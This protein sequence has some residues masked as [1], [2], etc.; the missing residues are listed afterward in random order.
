MLQLPQGIFLSSTITVASRPAAAHSTGRTGI[1]AER[2]IEAGLPLLTKNFRNSSGFGPDCENII[3]AMNVRKLLDW[4]KLLIYSHRWMGIAGGLLF[5][6]WF[7]SGVVIMYKG[8][9]ELT[10]EERLA[11]LPPVDL[12][13]ARL[14]P[15]EAAAEWGI[16]PTRVR[17]EMFYDGRP[18]YRFQG[19]TVVFAED[20]TMPPGA[21]AEEAVEFV[22]RWAPRH[23]A[24]VEYDGYLEDS[25][26]WTLQ[27]AQRQYMPLHRIAL[28]DPADTYYYVSEYTGEPVMK[29][30][31]ESRWW[32]F[33]SA[34]LH[35]VYFVPLRRETYW[36]NQFII[37]GSFAGAVMC[38]S[39][40]FIGIW[41]FSPG[42]RFRQSTRLP[43]ARTRVGC[44][45]ITMPDCYL[46]SSALPGLSAERF[47]L[48]RTAGRLEPLRHGNNAKP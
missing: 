44:D 39:G 46:A 40:I 5:V 9:P 26:Q 37:W 18:I 14:S 8:M 2:E 34:V 41:R 32:G 19:G 12:S 48:T 4:R 33:W 21:T 28:R 15:V 42:G 20:G 25:D 35:W 43:T 1:S 6:S 29:T 23:A 10:A 36:W 30:D 16:D 22:K 45:G 13:A 17:I 3:S 38:L 11:H 24:T 47:R 31:R 27:A 7:I